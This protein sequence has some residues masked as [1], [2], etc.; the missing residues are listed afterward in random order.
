M[1]KATKRPKSRDIFYALKYTK[2]AKSI[3]FFQWKTTAATACDRG[4]LLIRISP[5][6]R[7]SGRRPYSLIS[8][9]QRAGPAANHRR[10]GPDGPGGM[11]I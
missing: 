3:G 2:H 7:R 9:G 1:Y 8:L 6:W 5:A 10:I 4:D 11:G